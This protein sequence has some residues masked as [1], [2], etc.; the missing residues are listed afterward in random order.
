MKKLILM[1][2]AWGSLVTTQAQVMKSPVLQ[3]TPTYNKT[4]EPEI[5]PRSPFSLSEGILVPEKVKTAFKNSY[6]SEDVTW[7]RK[8][9]DYMATF[10]SK[11]TE[12]L[13]TIVLYD[14]RGG[15]VLKEREFLSNTG[16]VAISKYCGKHMLGK[17]CRAWEVES[18]NG[19]RSYFVVRD[20]EAIWFD[21][22]GEQISANDASLALHKTVSTGHRGLSGHKVTT[23]LKTTAGSHKA[24]STEHKTHK[25]HGSEY[26]K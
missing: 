8:G 14:A 12:S 11:G 6:G 5:L 7:T 17:N 3:K 9:N 24:G 26:Y 2:A 21:R 25:R 16:P 13:E 19:N 22:N 1:L 4:A 20:N 23:G 18:S 15:V 10:K